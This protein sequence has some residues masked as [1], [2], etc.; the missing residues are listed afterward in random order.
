MLISASAITN[1]IVPMQHRNSVNK[2]INVIMLRKEKYRYV[3]TKQPRQSTT[4]TILM[5]SDIIRLHNIYRCYKHQRHFAFFH[6][7]HLLSSKRFN[8]SIRITMKENIY[9]I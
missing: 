7:Q 9:I 3:Y 2:G 4:Q 6:L 1:I 8:T 5:C